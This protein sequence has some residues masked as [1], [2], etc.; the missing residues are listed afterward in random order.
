MFESFSIIF[1]LAA[2]LSFVNYKWLKLPSTIGTM[3]LAL[4]FAVFAIGS[5]NIFPGFYNFFCDIV[6]SSDFSTLLLDIM[7]SILLFAGAMHIDFHRLEKEK[8][9]VLVF[10]TIGV[11]LSTFIIGGALY[12]LTMLIGIDLPLIYCLIFG[13]LISPTDPIAVIGIIEEAGIDESTALKIEGESMF[14]DGIGVVVFTSLILI[15]SGDTENLGAEIGHLFLVEAVGGIALGFLLGWLASYFVKSIQENSQLATILSIAFVIGGYSIASHLGTSGPLAMVVAGL[16]LGGTISK[17]N[18]NKHTKKVMNEIWEVLD[19]SLNTVL[20]VLIGLSLHLITADPQKISLGLIVIVVA[21][22]ARFISIVLPFSLLR[23]KENR[24]KTSLLLTWGGLR[25][26]I[27]IALALSIPNDTYRPTI[28][29][30]TFM[31][32]LF[33]ILVQG[34]SLGKLVKKLKSIN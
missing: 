15:A 16:F 21:L 11:L 6:T 22:L 12:F 13:A 10:S 18:F 23:T 25:G 9:S 17:P 1:L 28:L 27:S 8:W 5:K 31:V 20:F 33:S 32:A 4:V 7:L 34:L 29:L 24:M 26:G 2:L 14:N 3:I 30:L 19:E